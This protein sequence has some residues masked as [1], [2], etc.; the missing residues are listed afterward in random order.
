MGAEI[1]K[2]HIEKIGYKRKFTI[3][4]QSDQLSLVK[5]VIKELNL[6]PKVV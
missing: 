3:L 4:D 1:L 5:E 2:K 6:D